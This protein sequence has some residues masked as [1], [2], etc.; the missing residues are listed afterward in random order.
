MNTFG[1]DPDAYLALLVEQAAVLARG[2][3]GQDHR[4]HVAAWSATSW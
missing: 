2:V 4:E 3:V 1:S